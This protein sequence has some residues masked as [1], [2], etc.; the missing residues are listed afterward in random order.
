MF[1]Y[2]KRLIFSSCSFVRRNQFLICSYG[3]HD[4]QTRRGWHQE[5][6]LKFSSTPTGLI[7]RVGKLGKFFHLSRMYRALPHLIYITWNLLKI[8]SVSTKVIRWEGH[9]ARQMNIAYI[10]LGGK[11]GG[12]RQI[13]RYKGRWK[14]NIQGERCSVHSGFIW[15][16]IGCS[17]GFL[18][19][20]NGS[21][22]T[23][24]GG[25]LT[26]WATVSF[27]RGTLLIA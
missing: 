6:S 18:W 3:C 11:L 15:I 10:M 26:N 12:T 22:G 13:V 5:T 7:E 4:S 1:S 25:D 24:E 2:R 20:Q 8:F 21:P 27:L 17:D 9:V 19:T 16:R 14:K 23:T